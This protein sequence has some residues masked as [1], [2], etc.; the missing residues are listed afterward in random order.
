MFNEEVAENFER[1]EIDGTTLQSERILRNESMNSLGLTTIGKKK[2][3]I[4]F[5]ESCVDAR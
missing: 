4:Y 3:I 1:D 2:I 5:H